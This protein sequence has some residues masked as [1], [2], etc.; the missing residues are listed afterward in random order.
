MNSLD[1]L[2]RA[3]IQA[4]GVVSALLLG[5][6]ALLVTFD[7]TLRNVG[8][9]TLP[10]IVE[11]SEYAMPVAT[12]LMAPWLLY[13]NQH[14]RVE[15]LVTSLPPHAARWLDQAADLVGLVCSLGL[16]WYGLKIIADSRGIGALIIKTLVFPEWWLFAPLPFAGAL[17]AVEFVRRMVRRATGAAS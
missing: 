16:L 2:Y 1:R 4:C 15:I 12:F 8:L 7:V 11:I 17:L 13:R 6:V 3:L 9:G 5:I 14:V 10:W